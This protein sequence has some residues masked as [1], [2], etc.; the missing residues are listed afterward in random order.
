MRNRTRLFAA[1]GFAAVLSLAAGQVVEEIVAV[2][3]DDV[4]T[5]SE[6]RGQYES[7]IQQLK[8]ALKGEELE[9]QV[10]FVKKELLNMMIT[11]LL[12][13]QV[14]KEKNL[15]VSDQ[16]RQTVENIKK[17]NNIES[18]DD[19]RRAIQQQGLEYNQWLKQLED[20]LMMQAIRYSEIERSIVLDDAETVNYYKQ[21]LTEFIEPEEFHIRAVYLGTEGKTAQALEEKK[22]LVSERLKAG[23]TFN[24]LAKEYTE[25]PGKESEGDLGTFKKGEL[26]KTLEQAVAKLKAGEMSDWLGTKNGW[27]LL[28]LEEKKESRQKTLDEVKKPIEERLYGEKR[29]KKTDEYIKDLKDKSYIKIL[30]PNPLGL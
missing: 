19:L 27:Y 3:N 24:A 29:Q 11:D 23:E 12:L 7:T 17:E 22:S 30:K 8:G 28:K 5:L 6:Y 16:V 25:G 9:K 26:D 1:A 21:H 14:A 20:N 18:D 15:N 4:I 13:K 10:E 2:V